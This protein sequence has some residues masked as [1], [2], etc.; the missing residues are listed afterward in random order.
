MVESLVDYEDAR[1]T[2]FRPDEQRATAAAATWILAFNARWA[3]GMGEEGVDASS[4]LAPARTRRHDYLS[5][6]W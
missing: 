1:G 2:P 3:V 4:S 6:R 5:L